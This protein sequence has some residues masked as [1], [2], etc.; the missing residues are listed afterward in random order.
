MLIAYG[1]TLNELVKSEN[2]LTAVRM[3]LDKENDCW[4]LILK[5]LHMLRVSGNG[6]LSITPPTRAARARR[7]GRKT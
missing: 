5:T 3:T 6:M 2:L 7:N 4:E 1:D